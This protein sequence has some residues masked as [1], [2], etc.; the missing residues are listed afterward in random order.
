VS[1]VGGLAEDL[2]H[3]RPFRRSERRALNRTCAVSVVF[4]TEEAEGAQMSAT[5]IWN[6]HIISPMGK[7]PV[8]FELVEN[9]GIITGSATAEGETVPVVNGKADGDDLIWEMSITKPMKMS[10]VMKLHIDG[11]TWAGTAKPKFFPASQV[12]GERA[13]S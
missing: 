11:D 5:G 8:R 6:A 7:N 2:A 13:A 1:P 4:I 10:F 3:A 12:I 9:D